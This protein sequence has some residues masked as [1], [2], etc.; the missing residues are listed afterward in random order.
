MITKGLNK[1]MAEKHHLYKQCKF[2]QNHDVFDEFKKRRNLVNR[3]LRDAHHKYSVNFFK[4]CETS[5]QKLNFFNT[6]LGNH[7][8][9]INGSG[10]EVDG[11]ESL[12]K[13]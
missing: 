3:K 6:K 10:I 12:T 2:F 1:L 4:K 7:K 9:G 8:Q 13:K 11:A 5:K